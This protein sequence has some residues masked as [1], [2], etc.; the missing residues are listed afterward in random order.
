MDGLALHCRAGFEGECAAE[1]QERAAALGVYGFCKTQPDSALV[2]FVCKAEEADH[3]AR[4]VSILS[5]VFVRQY[6]VIVA[7]ENTLSTEDRVTP[8]LAALPEDLPTCGDVW[9]ETT[10]TNDGRAL[11]PLCKKIT[12]ALRKAAIAKELLTATP[13]QNR[14]TLHVLFRSTHSALIGYSYSYNHAPFPMGIPRIRTPK[15]SPSR[16]GAKLAEAFKVMIP[17]EELEKRVSSGMN[18]VDLGACPGGVDRSAGGRGHDGKCGR[19]RCD[20][21]TVDGNWAGE[22]FSG[23]WFYIPTQETQYSVARLRYGGK[24]SSGGTPHG[25]LVH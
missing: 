5:L 11:S 10:D 18:A 9:T 24:A 23:G 20:R 17:K 19:Q 13:K 8:L 7:E 15:M 16:S 6:F 25:R 22:A 4:K 2:I 3:I 1:I 14:P 12:P 21:S